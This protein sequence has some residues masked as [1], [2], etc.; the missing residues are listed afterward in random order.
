MTTNTT[1]AVTKPA[2]KVATVKKA[3]VSKPGKP[4]GE[5][6]IVG[7]IEKSKRPLMVSDMAYKQVFIREGKLC[8]RVMNVCN[9]NIKGRASK[10][11][12]LWIVDLAAGKT[13]LSS[14]IP[15]ELVDVEIAITNK[16]V[17]PVEQGSL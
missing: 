10:K 4:V 13:F 15:V 9:G 16:R 3:A 8:M 14:D 6:K 5:V 1:T 12:H 11:E 2:R 17:A 7:D